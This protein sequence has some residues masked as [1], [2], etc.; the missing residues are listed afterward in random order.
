[1][2]RSRK[3]RDLKRARLAPAGLSSYLAVQLAATFVFK[4]VRCPIWHKAD[5]ARYQ[6]R[7]QRC[8]V[9]NPE[10]RWPRVI[11]RIAESEGSSIR[12]SIDAELCL[13]S[14]V[15]TGSRGRHRSRDRHR[16]CL[17]HNILGCCSNH[18]HRWQL[19]RPHRRQPRHRAQRPEHNCGG[20]GDGGNTGH[21]LPTIEP[22]Y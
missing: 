9:S 16:S 11:E 15:N 8:E 22:H 3:Q 19:R 12:Q 13:P 6:E 17:V 5:I 14:I 2:L 1:M 18:S 20:S 4:S 10:P 7:A 21:Q